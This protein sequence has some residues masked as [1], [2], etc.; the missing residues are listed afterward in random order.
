MGHK[1]VASPLWALYIR[2][3]SNTALT[4][5]H[6]VIDYWTALCLAGP[7]AEADDAHVSDWLDIDALLYEADTIEHD[8]FLAQCADAEAKAEAAI[9]RAME[10]D[11][12]LVDETD[13]DEWEAYIYA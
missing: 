9:E 1:G 3:M 6:E 12:R 7:P 5:Q 2:V 13:R 11:D 4:A 10:R 8:E